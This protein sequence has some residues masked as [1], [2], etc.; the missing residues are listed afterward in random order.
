MGM[1]VQRFE[2]LGD[3]KTITYHVRDAFY[4]ILSSLAFLYGIIQAP[5]YTRS[6]VAL[7]RLCKEIPIVI[8][9]NNF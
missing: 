2:N 4:K 8:K 3:F 6:P 7:Y 1:L 9:S 5:I